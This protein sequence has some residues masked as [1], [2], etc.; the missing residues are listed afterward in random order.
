VKD[1]G[2]MMLNFMTKKLKRGGVSFGL[3]KTE[4]SSQ[5][6]KR[7]LP[8]SKREESTGQMSVRKKKIRTLA[9]E[10]EEKM[11]SVATGFYSG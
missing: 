9:A 8:V 6:K 11:G 3:T 1:S 2:S 7:T 10:R 5:L 4:S